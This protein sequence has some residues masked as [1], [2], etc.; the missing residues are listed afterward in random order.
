MRP[1]KAPDEVD[2]T[3]NGRKSSM[4][5]HVFKARGFKARGTMLNRSAGYPTNATANAMLQAC[6]RRSVTRSQTP[7][8][9]DD[10][11]VSMSESVSG[12]VFSEMG[13]V[14]NS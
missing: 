8:A 10:W 6:S 3:L 12:G 5:F 14:M 2:L 4:Y 1:G 7:G 13:V 11:E 9:S